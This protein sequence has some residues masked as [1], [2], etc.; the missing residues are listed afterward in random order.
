MPT[1][2]WACAHAIPHPPALTATQS[3]GRSLRDAV[4]YLFHPK[5]DP[6]HTQETEQHKRASP[7]IPR[8]FKFPKALGTGQK[9]RAGLREWGEASPPV[10]PIE[11]GQLLI[12]SQREHPRYGSDRSAACKYKP[13]SME[14][15]NALGWKGPQSPSGSNPPAIGTDIFHQPSLLRAPSNLAFSGCLSGLP[16][17][18]A[19][20]RRASHPPGPPRPCPVMSSSS[21]SIFCS[22]AKS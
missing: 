6:T 9:E 4:S 20:S 8:T 12:N 17:H 19:G 10:L 22:T 2:P 15:R 14:S 18:I 1:I 21:K 13:N 16:V 5:Q 3:W 11:R 7:R